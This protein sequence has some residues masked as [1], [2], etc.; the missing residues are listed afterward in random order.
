MSLIACGSIHEDHEWFS[1][2]FRGRQEIFICVF[3]CSSMW[4]ILPIREWRCQDIDQ[5]LLH[6]IIFFLSVFSS[7]E[8]PFGVPVYCRL[9]LA[10]LGKKREE[11]VKP[12]F[13]MSRATLVPQTPQTNHSQ[14]PSPV[15]ALNLIFESK[16]QPV[17]LDNST[18]E[19]HVPSRRK[20]SLKSYCS[21]DF[22]C[23]AFNAIWY[24]LWCH[25][26]WRLT[27]FTFTANVWHKG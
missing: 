12:T 10:G 5:V 15:E 11:I 7:S 6:E 4:A 20:K 14:C 19:L 27:H 21:V 17:E 23:L 16:S 26:A 13:F 22:D 2:D 18:I 9:Q 25:V 3:G 1:D 24:D 8:V